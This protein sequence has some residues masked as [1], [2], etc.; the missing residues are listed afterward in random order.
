MY[1]K[2]EPEKWNNNIYIRKS[3]NCYAYALNIISNK[4]ANICKNKLNSNKLNSNI[5]CPRPQPNMPLGHHDIS[6]CKL[7]EIRMLKDNPKI[8]PI[9]NP[10]LCL[11]NY[12]LIALACT[13]DKSDYHFYRQ[14]E[15]KLWSHKNGWR[16]AT[17]K[18]KQNKLI[19]DPKY[20]DRDK[21]EIFCGYYMVPINSKMKLNLMK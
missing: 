14:D 9:S 1:P 15:N 4:L 13:K 21:F 10:N 6:S 11:K 3:H 8:K 17:N 16:K 12:Y 5:N 2:Y 20:S 19:T 7:I 18:D